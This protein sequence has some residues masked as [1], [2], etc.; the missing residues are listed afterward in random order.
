MSV[1]PEEAVR[2]LRER[3]GRRSKDDLAAE[4]SARSMLPGL[5]AALREAGAKRIVLF[6]SLTNGLF[7]ANSDIDLGVVGIP[8]RV[9]AKLE[10]ELSV[11]AHRRVELAN[12]ESLAPA[13][14][15]RIEQS[16][17]ELE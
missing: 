14:S 15:E 4:A 1:T 6:G 17:Q 16:G 11:R 8:E 12:L 5:T 2:H 13:L 3:L 7:R 10:R 9:L